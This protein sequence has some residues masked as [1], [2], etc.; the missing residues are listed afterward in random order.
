MN[1]VTEILRKGTREILRYMPIKESVPT[2]VLYGDLLK[3]RT[4]LITGGTSG[5]G[6]S[7]ADSFVKNGACVIITGRNKIKIDMAVKKLK[8]Q[9]DNAL[10]YGFEL[11]NKKIKEMSEKFN[12]IL[13]EINNRRIDILVNNAGVINKTQFWDSTEEDFDNVINTNLKGTYF[14]TK[15][16]AK[17][18]L[19]NKIKGNI[20]NISSSSSIRPALNSYQ[21][22]KWG[23]RAFTKGLAKEL[24]S[25]GIVV[26]SIAP[27][28]T[29]TDMLL[30]GD[31][32]INR[33]NSPIG[34]YATSDEIASLSTILVS[35]LSRMIDGDTIFATGGCGNLTFD[36]WD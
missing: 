13:K 36:D 10:I 3:N 16:V 22:T 33:P 15:I 29:A 21:L 7:I 17:Y 1:K 28:P 35:N 24:S 12:Y 5:I 18:M 26:N 27:G 6:F 32:N 4:A 11:D 25:K 19:E 9:N 2:S 34:R 20:L 8:S 14:I 30:D 23:I 31:N